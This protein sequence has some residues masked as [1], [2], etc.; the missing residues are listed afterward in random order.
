M[1]MVEYSNFST[2]GSGRLVESTDGKRMV[3]DLRELGCPD[4]IATRIEQ[5][6]VQHGSAPKPKA[7]ARVPSV[8][9]PPVSQAEVDGLK[10][11]LKA[12]KQIE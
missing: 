6:Y 10:D 4:E 11:R 5:R 2:P 9:V 1:V 12:L 7:P 3:R 8:S